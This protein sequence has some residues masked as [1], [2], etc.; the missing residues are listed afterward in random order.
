VAVK[1]YAG[2][3]KCV[4]NHADARRTGPRFALRAPGVLMLVRWSWDDTNDVLREFWANLLAGVA[5]TT[6][7]CK[8][9]GLCLSAPGATEPHIWLVLAR[10]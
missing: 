8:L 3:D 5:V 9:H 1:Q 6:C 2:G 7:I 4:S 10:G